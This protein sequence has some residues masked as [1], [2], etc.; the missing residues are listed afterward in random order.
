MLNSKDFP[1]PDVV[2]KRLKEYKRHFSEKI[3]N[4]TDEEEKEF[5]IE[6]LAKIDECV[7]N[8]CKY[9]M[10]V[11]S[12]SSTNATIRRENDGEIANELLEEN[13]RERSRCHSK[14]IKNVVL[15]DR[16]CQR[17]K[18]PIVFDLSDEFQGNYAP[19][20]P[21]TPE[22]KS[23]MT[24][25]EREKRREIGNF[26]LYFAISCNTFDLEKE[27]V[28]SY[29]DNRDTGRFDGEVLHN[30]EIIERHVSKGMKQNIDNMLE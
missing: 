11:I 6:D 14:V 29:V 3:N 7:E 15:I 17:E 22:E 23:H 9:S 4:E 1:R 8:M 10:S 28:Q 18:L 16:I 27:V 25:R 19:L 21:T 5:D 2:L 20:L 24:P 30:Q 12:F 26:A 13:D